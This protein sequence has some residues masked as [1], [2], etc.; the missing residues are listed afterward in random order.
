MTAHTP[1]IV[2]LLVGIEPGSA[3][4]D[5]RAQRPQA[6]ENAQKSYLALFRP[7]VSGNVS[8]EERYAVATFVAGLHRQPVVA[9]FYA[10]GLR[11]SGNKAL[12][13]AV[14]TEI[15]RGAAEGPYGHYPEGPLSVENKEGLLYRVSGESRDVLGPRQS[16]AFEH[17]HLLT[18]RPRDA[19]PQALQALLEAGW[20][21]TDIVTLSQLV[22]FL[23]FQIRLIAGLRALAAV[24]RTDSDVVFTGALASSLL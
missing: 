14:E 17:A 9:D 13:Q 16:A 10:S 19:N 7:E 1:D 21:A 24:K 18:F 20:S 8:A 4:D 22:S 12:G 15:A 23:A 3:L 11:A 6:R 5:I 2:D